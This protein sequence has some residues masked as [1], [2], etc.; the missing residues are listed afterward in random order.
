MPERSG[1]LVCRAEDE[2]HVVPD[3]E[4][5]LLTPDCWCKP[6]FDTEANI[7]SSGVW[8]HRSRDGREMTERH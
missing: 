4:E 1:W 5:H 3:G 7:E 8:V 2:M 6:W